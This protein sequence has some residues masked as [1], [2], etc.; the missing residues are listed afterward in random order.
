MDG[1]MSKLKHKKIL[2]FIPADEQKYDGA[3]AAIELHK[4]HTHKL[5]LNKFIFIFCMSVWPCIH[6][7]EKK[8]I[9]YGNLV[10]N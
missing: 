3:A 1:K 8:R 4:S 5:S 6:H 2:L 7:D 10:I 9:I